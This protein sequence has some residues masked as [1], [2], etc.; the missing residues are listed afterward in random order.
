MER[1]AGPTTEFPTRRGGRHLIHSAEAHR[2]FI[3]SWYILSH[4]Q[5][6]LNDPAWSIL[7][8]DEIRRRIDALPPPA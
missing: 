5:Y 2:G 1:S 3:C 4:V 7:G 8:E 6:A